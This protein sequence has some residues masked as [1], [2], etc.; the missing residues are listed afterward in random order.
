[1][2]YGRN[3]KR[4]IKLYSQYF[5]RYFNRLVTFLIILDK[6]EKIYLIT[7]M[8]LKM[9]FNIVNTFN[10]IICFKSDR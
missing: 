8:L 6:T 9:Y 3:Y 10:F 5:S 1:M 7:A 4:N 2:K